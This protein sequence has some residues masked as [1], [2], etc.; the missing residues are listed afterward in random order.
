MN[1]KNRDKN[2][3]MRGGLGMKKEVDEGD[4]HIRC[5]QER[6]MV[7]MAVLLVAVLMED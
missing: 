6:F 4:F 5:L 3:G 2:R 1:W 7:K